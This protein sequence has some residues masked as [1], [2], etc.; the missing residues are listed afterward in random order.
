MKNEEKIFM[1]FLLFIMLVMVFFSFNY[2][3]GS[4][5]LPMISGVFSALIMGFMVNMS[6][7]A[8]ITSWYQ[9]F[10]KKSVLSERTM[11]KDEKKREISVIAW[12]SGCTVVIYFL[13]FLVGIPL[14]LFLFLKLWAKESWL[15]SVVLATTVLVVVYFAFVYILRVPLH[16]GML[17]T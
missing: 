4:K 1:I 12:F 5:I 11:K 16:N 10:E 6:F 9:K 8:K 17:F 3:G 7:S 14:F 2:S 15:L 13:G